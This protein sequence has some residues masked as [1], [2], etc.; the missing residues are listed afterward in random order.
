M[1]GAGHPAATSSMGDSIGC[2]RSLK[3]EHQ[4]LGPAALASDGDG[5]GCQCVTSLRASSVCVLATSTLMQG[6][7]TL[8]TRVGGIVRASLIL[9]FWPAVVQFQPPLSHRRFVSCAA[10]PLRPGARRLASLALGHPW[11]RSG[12]IRGPGRVKRQPS[13]D[14]RTFGLFFNH[15]MTDRT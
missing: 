3:S 11:L 5:N 8:R 15:L 14:W 4:F 12:P 6:R 13:M 10:S 1:I 2:L 9:W 7:L